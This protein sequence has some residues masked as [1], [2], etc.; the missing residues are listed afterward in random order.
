MTLKVGI[1]GCGNIASLYNE[2]FSRWPVTHLAAYA[3]HPLTEVV[4]V[5]DRDLLR[6]RSCA[7]KWKIPHW[8]TDYGEMLQKE[9]FDLIS[10][11]TSYEN[12]AE[13]I[14]EIAKHNIK[15]ILCEKPFANNLSDAREVAD[16]CHK[17]GI[18]LAI[19]F[20]RRHDRL[21]RHVKENLASLVGDVK[22]VVF[23]YAGGI[24]NNGSHAF[25]LLRFYFGEIASLNAVVDGEF[26]DSNFI[27][28]PNLT[29][30]LRFA[31]GLFGVMTSCTIPNHSTFEISI[32]GTKARLDLLNK[33]FFGYDYRYIS[34]VSSETLPAVTCSS[35]V[36]N[37][38]FPENLPRDLFVKAIDN[39]VKSIG[40]T[41]QDF[42][43]VSSARNG[44]SALELVSAAIT[45][46][47]TRQEVAL[48]FTQSFTLPPLQGV[49]T[50][51][52]RN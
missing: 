19:N 37:R 30:H 11:C 16:L 12:H 52:K 35:S 7:E 6:A 28:D 4:A 38:D 15:A 51:W 24:V 9:E 36:L 14:R 18:S 8:Y 47:M 27:T 32:I 2:H 46:A 31:S 42:K 13:I 34:H 22:K 33:P 5:C 39:L 48:P 20:Q 43:L 41:N 3:E 17:K 45:S 29:I 23:L 26:P 1:I 49:F 44:I 10:I 50:T 21:H 40:N 25:D